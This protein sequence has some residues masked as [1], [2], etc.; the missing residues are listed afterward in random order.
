MTRMVI[1]A[2]NGTYT[3]KVDVANKGIQAGHQVTV[4]LD[5]TATAG[6]ISISAKGVEGGDFEAIPDGTLDL[7]ALLSLQFTFVTTEFQ[8]VVSGFTGTATEIV[9]NDTVVGL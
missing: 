8:F 7:T 3:H 4:S 9:I 5:G 6:T 1:A 2:A